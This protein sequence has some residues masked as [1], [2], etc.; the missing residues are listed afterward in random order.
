MYKSTHDLKY[1]QKK[2]NKKDLYI[3]HL[4]KKLCMWFE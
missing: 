3:Y 1:L 4:M 2:S